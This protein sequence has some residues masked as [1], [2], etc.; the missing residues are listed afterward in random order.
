MA[1][2]SAATYGDEEGFTIGQ[3]EVAKI[4]RL[5]ECALYSS[6]GAIGISQIIR[7][8]VKKMLDA[9][10][11][12][13]PQVATPIDAMTLIAH[14]IGKQIRPFF[15]TA[16]ASV[17]LVGNRVAVQGV[18]CKSLLAVAFKSGVH[19]FQFN[20]SGAPERATEELPFVALGSGQR[21]ADPFLA[22]LKR[23]LWK[24]RR[25]SLA[26]GR[27]VAAWTI[28]HVAKTNAGGVAL[29]LQL[30]TL[31]KADKGF[32]AEFVKD[33]SEQMQ[34]VEDAEASLLQHVLKKGTEEAPPKVPQPS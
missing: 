10:Q 12:D 26:E 28:A 23:V 20:H 6:T 30:A 29:P 5:N 33:T 7:N 27:F 31:S 17:P 9:K 1:S 16:G 24:D 19:L 18:F 4:I 2:D 15:D 25:P 8:A 13:G 21:I 32:R 14:E 11:L 34:A 3:Q 22:L